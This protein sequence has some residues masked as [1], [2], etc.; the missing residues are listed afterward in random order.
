MEGIKKRVQEAL[1]KHLND[2]AAMMK[3]PNAREFHKQAMEL[4]M[5][6]VL[7]EERAKYDVTVRDG[8]FTVY[9]IKE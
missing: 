3:Y 7:G 4:A 6:E 5:Q 2:T 8:D 9:K 1:M